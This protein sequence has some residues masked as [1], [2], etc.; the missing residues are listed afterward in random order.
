MIV[1]LASATTETVSSSCGDNPP[2]E[3]EEHAH[4]S[5]AVSKTDI[6]FFMTFTFLNT[7]KSYHFWDIMTDNHMC[8]YGNHYSL[9]V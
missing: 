4:K 2:E 9:S 8:R 6:D 3:G 5:A 7:A 1:G